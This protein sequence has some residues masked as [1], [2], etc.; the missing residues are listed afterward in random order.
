MYRLVVMVSGNGSNLQALIDNV[1]RNAKVDA[2][3][4]PEPRRVGSTRGATS[5]R[6]DD[7]ER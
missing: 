3:I 7:D 4:P 1:H 6:I 5:A 2:E